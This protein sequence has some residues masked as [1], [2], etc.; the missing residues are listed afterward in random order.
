MPKDWVPVTIF[1]VVVV[2]SLVFLY[3]LGWWP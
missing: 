3:W 2:G 1:V